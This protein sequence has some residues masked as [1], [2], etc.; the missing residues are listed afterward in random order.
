MCV[1]DKVHAVILSEDK[2]CKVVPKMSTTGD[3]TI[4]VDLVERGW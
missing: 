3:E 4:T 2:V 1:F